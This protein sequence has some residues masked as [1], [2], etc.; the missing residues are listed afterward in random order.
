M[1]DILPVGHSVSRMIDALLDRIYADG[2]T[3]DASVTDRSHKMLNITPS[4][5]RFLDVLVSDAAPK[6]ILEIGTSNGYST[7]WL[8]RAAERIDAKIDSVDCDV[9]KHSVATQNVRDAGFQGIVSLHTSDAGEFLS[10]CEPSSYDFVFLDA[11]RSRY[12]CWTAI[13]LDVIDFGTL[14][15]D[16]ALSHAE[17]FSPF[18]HLI[19]SQTALDSVI[20]PIG[21]GQLVVR[22]KNRAVTKRHT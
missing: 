6:R 20:L 15:V 2:Q 12:V 4:T 16:N 19:A 18:C 7:I 13:L 5:G 1:T 3:N 9:E 21:K 11:D 14:V 17:E 22:L 8:A 10:T